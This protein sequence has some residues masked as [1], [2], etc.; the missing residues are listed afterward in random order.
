MPGYSYINHKNKEILYVDHRG[1]KSQEIIS[2]IRQMIPISEK[3]KD[4]S[5][6][7]LFDFRD[8]IIDD[9]IMKFIKSPENVNANKYYK[10]SAILG[11]TGMRKVLLNV[12]NTLL[13]REV[14]AFENEEEA[15]EYLVSW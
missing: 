6:L 2:N 12:F 11:V 9:E 3:C 14:K 5:L 4:K 8:V 7:G 13:G 10:K 15:K 1:L